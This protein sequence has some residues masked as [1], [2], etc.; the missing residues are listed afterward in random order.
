MKYR[1]LLLALLILPLCAKAIEFATV[2]TAA[3]LYDAPSVRG[4]RLF[5]IRR[6]TPVEIVV[7][8]K[9]WNKVRDAE[10]TL[11]WIE[12]Q[13]LS[14]RRTLIVTAERATIRQRAD[15]GSPV[16]FE[17]ERNVSLE[18]VSPPSGGWIRARHRDGQAGFV[19]LGQVWGF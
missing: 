9:D 19:R 11:A 16:V 10:G 17:A 14:N 8:I 4:A 12:K 5:V 6:D 15:E 18:Y 1:L 7:S 3:I 13:Y 2:D